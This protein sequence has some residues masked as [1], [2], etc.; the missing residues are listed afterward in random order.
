M[1]I[2]TDLQGIKEPIPF[3]QIVAYK[4]L[5][6]AL[7]A[8]HKPIHKRSVGQ[9]IRSVGQIFADVGALDPR[10][11]TMGAIYF[12]LVRQFTNYMK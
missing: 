10:I 12:R 6:G 5:T 3:L 7:A 9:Y 2:P 8:N 11:N 1:S 4:V